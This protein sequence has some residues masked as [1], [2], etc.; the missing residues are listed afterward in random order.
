[1]KISQLNKKAFFKYNEK[2]YMVIEPA[3]DTEAKV[4]CLHDNTIIDLEADITYEEAKILFEVE[5]PL[6]LCT[7]KQ[8]DTFLHANKFYTV[9]NNGTLCFNNLQI[10]EIE[11][12]VIIVKRRII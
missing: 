12:E 5:Y 4:F 8:G 11:D 9:T 1:M 2:L 3:A 7:A 10:G 6:T